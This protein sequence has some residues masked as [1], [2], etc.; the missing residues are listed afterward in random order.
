MLPMLSSLDGRSSDQLASQP[1]STAT[2]AH[3]TC[4]AREAKLRGTGSPGRAEQTHRPATFSECRRQQT[5]T[6]AAREAKLREDR[7]SWALEASGEMQHTSRTLEEPHRLSCS[8][9]GWGRN[10]GIQQGRS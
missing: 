8:T 9:C 10:A 1:A 4:A 7:L 2:P 6:C 5:L 3:H